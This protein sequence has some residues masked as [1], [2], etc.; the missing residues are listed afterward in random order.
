M[1][2]TIGVPAFNEDKSLSR[3]LQS[4]CSQVW[5]KGAQYHL[6]VV[7]NGCTD[8]TVQV[9]LAFGRSNW[10]KC[11]VS[12]RGDQTCWRYESSSDLTYTVVE[13]PVARKS[14]ALNIIH[15]IYPSDVVLL[16]DADVVL[17]PG[18]IAAMSAA[19]ERHPRCGAVA[20]R[21]C[22]YIPPRNWAQG[23][24][25]E[26]ARVAVAKS[27]NHFD[28]H[29][30]RLDGKGLGYHRDIVEQ[31]P[32]LVAVDTWLEGISWQSV[33]GCVYLDDVCV[34]YRFPDTLGDLVRQYAR[35]VRSIRHLAHKYPSLLER[36]R[37]G[38]A[39]SCA[40]RNKP[41]LLPRSIGW[42]FLRWVDLYA[43][44]EDCMIGRITAEKVEAWE[45]VQSTKG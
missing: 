21:Y 35:Y 22:G 18:V 15:T 17:G 2:Y 44:Y 26:V 38:R 14:L 12:R 16:F 13:V 3:T 40:D 24:F 31:H 11:S 36:V 42:L 37:Q 19:M 45:P 32:N 20:V 10:E 9:A 25:S 8:A 6:V 28:Q 27:I 39:V 1:I 7:A 41:R 43:R 5:P 34:H 4:I 23:L 33:G 30:P 29:C